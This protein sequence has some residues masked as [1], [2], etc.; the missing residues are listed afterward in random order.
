MTDLVL[1]TV[2]GG[3]LIGY[4]AIYRSYKNQIRRPPKVKFSK[5]K[6]FSRVFKIPEI[7]FEDQRLTSFAGLVLYQPLFEQLQLKERFKRCFAHL[8]VSEIFAHHIIM[9]LLVFHLIMGF[10]KVRD[11]DYYR[12]DPLVKRLLGLNRLPDVSTV[13]RAL[14]SVD[15]TAIDKVR[16]LNRDLVISRVKELGLS[17]LT[18]DFDGSVI[19]TT[20]RRAEGTA[21]GYNKRKKGARSYYPLLCTIAQTG[22][23]FDVLFRPGNVHDS[24]G[25]REFIEQCLRLLKEAMPGVILEARM[26]SAFFSDEIV[27]FLQKQGVEFSL[28]VPFERFAELKHMIQDRKRWKRMDDRWSWF[29]TL[30]KPQKWDRRFRF[31]LIRQR[32]PLVFRGPIQL[33]LFIPH[34]EGYEF[35]AIVTNKRIKAKKVLM[36]HNGRAD[37]EGVFGELKSQSQMDYIPVRRLGGNQFY[38]MASIL[39]HNLTREI[40]MVACLKVRGTTEKRSPLWFFEELKTLRHLIIQR[41]GRLTTPKGKLT[42]TLNGNEAVKRDFFMFLDAFKE[43]A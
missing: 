36:F 3:V 33:D 27:T 13:S 23:V 20:Q 39:A 26:D 29:E 38:S 25:A 28:S 10:R 34:E 16:A 40:Q 22:Q 19:W 30:W 41:A 31:L 43:A 11:L 14:R 12:D 37:Q 4:C 1:K 9:V 17:R 42:L 7:K 15:K 21:V 32:V 35:K 8:K 24:N 6:I 18:V 2:E 5:T